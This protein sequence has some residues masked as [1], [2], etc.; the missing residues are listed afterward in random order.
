MKVPEDGLRLAD[1]RTLEVSY[2]DAA[3]ALPGPRPRPANPSVERHVA[4]CVP[5]LGLYLPPVVWLIGI[6]SDPGAKITPSPKS[7]VGTQ[8]KLHQTLPG[9][10]LAALM[11][12]AER[13]DHGLLGF[14]AVV[15][16]LHQC[17]DQ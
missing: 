14:F 15:A 12:A 10:L 6:A 16:E 1:L 3:E 8:R 2:D 7:R 11:E 4:L 9:K 17:L 5:V 13:A